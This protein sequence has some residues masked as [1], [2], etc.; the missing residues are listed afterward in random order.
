[1]KVGLCF[2]V[3]SLVV[4]LGAAALLP[5]LT[6]QASDQPGSGQSS[7]AQQ[8]SDQPTM[9]TEAYG[10]WLHRCVRVEDQRRLCEVAQDVTAV[11]DGRS[12]TLLR[13]AITLDDDAGD[14][15]ARHRLVIVTPLSVDLPSGLR[16]S[17]EGEETEPFAYRSC[18]PAGCWIE[19]EASPRL[20][21]LLKGG[22]EARALFA[23]RG[24]QEFDVAFSLAGITAA[25]GALDRAR[26]GS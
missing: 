18:D 4:G 2:I 16:L 26:Q 19:V 6:V 15:N 5:R 14:E 17:V 25:L 21:D 23:L 11:R 7:E 20:I 12:S 3:F 1:M 13:I 24:G 9:V 10:D 8:V 22:A